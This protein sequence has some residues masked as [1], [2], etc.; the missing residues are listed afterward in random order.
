[1][2]IK[3]IGMNTQKRLTLHIIPPCMPSQN[4]GRNVITRLE[5]CNYILKPLSFKGRK[6]TVHQNRLKKCFDRKIIFK[7]IK[8]SERDTSNEIQ[9]HR[10]RKEVQEA[11]L[12]ELDGESIAKAIT[13]C[14]EESSLVNK[15]DSL[16]RE[17]SIMSERRGEKKKE[18]EEDQSFK[19]SKFPNNKM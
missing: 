13:T 4:A 16:T 10:L 11:K 14:N 1:M 3:M 5:D 7:N 9:E 15:D 19:V 18:N 8:Q 2:S 6:V 12:I 17:H